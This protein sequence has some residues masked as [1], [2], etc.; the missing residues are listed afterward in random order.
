MIGQR[1]V[2]QGLEL[3]PEFLTNGFTLLPAGSGLL[4][5]A[6]VNAVLAAWPLFI[7]QITGPIERSATQSQRNAPVFI[8][9]PREP[10]ARDGV[11]FL[12]IRMISP[13]KPGTRPNDDSPTDCGRPTLPPAICALTDR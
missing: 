11:W 10:Y 8:A 12:T 9:D 5:R 13:K 6:R 4:T 2:Q 7:R 1:F 3:V